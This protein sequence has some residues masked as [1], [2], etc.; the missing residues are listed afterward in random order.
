MCGRRRSICGG[1]GGGGFI[2][3]GQNLSHL[4]SI[5][6]SRESIGNDEHSTAHFVEGQKSEIDDA[7]FLV[8]F[9]AVLI[10]PDAGESFKNAV[11]HLGDGYVVQRFR[12][13]RRLG[14]P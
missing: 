6:R 4:N 11:Q 9:W 5:H 8:A 3:S 1:W 2:S 7:V 13:V 12:N 10:N 14:W